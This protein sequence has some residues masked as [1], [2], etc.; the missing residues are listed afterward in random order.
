[1]FSLCELFGMLNELGLGDNNLVMF[2]YFRIPGMSLDDC[3]V[4]LMV[5]ANVIKLLNYIFGCKE[6]E[7]YIETGVSLVELHLVK[8]LVVSF[9]HGKRKEKVVSRCVKESRLLILEWPDMGKEDEHIDTSNHPSI[10]NVCLVFEPTNDVNVGY[11]DCEN[12]TPGDI[13]EK[14]QHAG[15]NVGE[16]EEKQEE[17]LVEEEEGG[18]FERDANELTY[19][20][21]KLDMQHFHFKVDAKLDQSRMFADKFWQEFGPGVLYINELPSGDKCDDEQAPQARKRIL[22]VIRREYAG[23]E[24]IKDS[25]FLCYNTF[26]LGN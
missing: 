16:E 2:T 8:S 23:K 20:K 6:I 9:S 4:P 26:L 25:D 12:E 17:G 1:M 3:L 24:Y 13:H 22:W 7:V 19:S 11:L 5:D 21:P 14:F 15:K 18:D 10:S